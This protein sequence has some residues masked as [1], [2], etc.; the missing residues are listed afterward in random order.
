MSASQEV[1]QLGDEI[2]PEALQNEDALKR[3]D[4]VYDGARRTV[5]D[6]PAA[7]SGSW[8]KPYV[9]AGS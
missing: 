8:V 2:Q 1:M 3:I 4:R 7:G 9:R 5:K 6:T